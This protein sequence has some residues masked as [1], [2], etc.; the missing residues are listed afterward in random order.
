[1]SNVV[2]FPTRPRPQ[3]HWLVVCGRNRAAASTLAGAELAAR[4]LWDETPRVQGMRPR[5][6]GPLQGPPEQGA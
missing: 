3:V 6:V 4:V 2:Q 5:I 1:M